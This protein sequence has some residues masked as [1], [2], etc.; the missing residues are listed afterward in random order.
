MPTSLRL[1]NNRDLAAKYWGEGKRLLFQ[2]KQIL[3]LGNV[4]Q[5]S[6]RRV[7]PDGTRIHVKQVFGQD[8]IFIDSPFK[9]GKK[10]WE[11]QELFIFLFF[12]DSQ[13]KVYKLVL[14]P[15]QYRL[16]EKE[17]DTFPFGHTWYSNHLNP[18]KAPCPTVL[19]REDNSFHYI[20]TAVDPTIIPSKNAYDDW[21]F[22]SG[23]LFFDWIWDG[24][25]ET[26]PMAQ[27]FLGKTH[28]SLSPFT[29]TGGFSFRRG[30]VVQFSR[31][32]CPEYSLVNLLQPGPIVRGEETPVQNTGDSSYAYGKRGYT[33]N[34]LGIAG[35]WKEVVV[36]TGTNPP[37]IP[38]PG[39]TEDY[40]GYWYFPWIPYLHEISAFRILD[41]MIA[42][43]IVWLHPTIA[44]PRIYG[45]YY[46]DADGTHLIPNYLVDEASYVDALTN[47][48]IL[49]TSVLDPP[50][51]W[52]F[53]T[54]FAVLNDFTYTI[55]E[56]TVIARGGAS[57][58]GKYH[59]VIGSLGNK[60]VLKIVNEFNIAIS[61]PNRTIVTHYQKNS[62]MGYIYY[63]FGG[64]AGFSLPDGVYHDN[65]YGT[66]DDNDSETREMLLS[67]KLIAGD[68][69]IEAGDSVL[70]YLYTEHQNITENT[71]WEEEWWHDPAYPP[72]FFARRKW[73]EY[74]SRLTRTT[75]TLTG[76]ASRSVVAFEVLDFDS[77]YH[78]EKGEEFKDLMLFYK[79]I[80]IHHAQESQHINIQD[81]YGSGNL[82]GPRGGALISTSASS[83]YSASGIRK[84]EYFLFYKIGNK[85]DKVKLAEFN[86]ELSTDPDTGGLIHSGSGERLWG[87]SCQINKDIAV[88]HFQKESYLN[89]G[90]APGYDSPMNF[91]DISYQGAL[92]LW[93]AEKI[94]VGC[95]NV[96]SEL[97]KKAGLIHKEFEFDPA[98]T[99][100]IYSVGL[101]R[102][103]PEKFEQEEI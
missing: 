28:L 78:V 89:N 13:F 3:G 61:R 27:P 44:V 37:N 56:N 16:S 23:L 86:S 1:F 87:V 67:Q 55:E 84:V 30:G 32:F 18:Y 99:E 76:S 62:N 31:Q 10:E 74:S 83:S 52:G 82:T 14:E 45:L 25:Y 69:E 34:N 91:E 71:A 41:V 79:K 94:V 97:A 26:P 93:S 22:H 100:L 15:G 40:L 11:I 38:A 33:L 12:N 98:P 95:I 36:P 2:L 60:E 102:R 47:S 88:Y 85:Q 101:H 49:N 54:E 4:P 57:A 5:G 19:S 70:S 92:K 20:D 53:G 50:G 24:Y 73:L 77:L 7:Y 8:F 81:N 6:L 43:P 39:G 96:G 63:V 9:G 58:S 80:T 90:T 35:T 17:A 65:S 48:T 103:K 75:K 46:T 59:S 51:C 64:E 42:V 29:V 68:L 21:H 66:T 72:W